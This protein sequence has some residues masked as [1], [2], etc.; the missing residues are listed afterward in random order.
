[1]IDEVNLSLAMPSTTRTRWDLR[2]EQ[3]IELDVAGPEGLFKYRLVVE[4]DSNDEESRIVKETL[5]LADK[6]LFTFNEGQVQLYKDDGQPGPTFAGNVRRSG[7]GAVVPGSS[8]K[9]LTWFKRWLG[10]LVVLRPNPALIEGRAERE[11]RSLSLSCD[12]F[13]SWYRTMWQERP[14]EVNAAL[15]DLSELLDGFTGLAIRVD[16]RR[17]GWLRATFADP[18]DSNRRKKDIALDFDELSDGQ[19]ALIVLYVVLHTQIDGDRTVL[20]DEPDNY[21]SLDEVQP[22]LMEALCRVRDR[23]EAQLF[24]ISHNAQYID[25]LAPED[26]FII[27]RDGGGPSRIRPFRSAEA[28]APSEIIARGGLSQEADE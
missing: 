13:A 22:F 10:E 20:L 8:N 5:H 18:A 15:R 16:E 12:N 2:Q 6:P 26:G 14:Q 17:I 25:Q 9:L 21:T 4:H 23:P 1:M 11:D 7:L 24:I 19:R 27:S 3:R 28:L